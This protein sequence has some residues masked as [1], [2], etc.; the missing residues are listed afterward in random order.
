METIAPYLAIP[1][2]VIILMLFWFGV[3][4][5]I[6]QMA[7]W[8]K[9]VEKYPARQPWNEKCWSLQSAYI[10]WAQY[11]GV[12]RV[13]ADAEGVHFSVIFPFSVSQRPFSVPWTDITGHKKRVYFIYGVE[14]QFQQVPSIP[15]KISTR[16]AD[17]LVEASNGAWKYE[18]S[19]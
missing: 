11:R 1:G 10:R 2:A 16:L 13:C 4:W 15:I 18:Q 12:L 8:P 3:V 19:E 9:L 7:G 14:L 6:A 5:F 17:N